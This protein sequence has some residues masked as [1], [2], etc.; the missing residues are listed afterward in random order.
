MDFPHEKL[1]KAGKTSPDSLRPKLDERVVKA[2]AAHW[3]NDDGGSQTNER[4]G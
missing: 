1:I 3:R 2:D 4:G